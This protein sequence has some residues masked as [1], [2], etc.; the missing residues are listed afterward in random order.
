MS[1]LVVYAL[2]TYA[3]ARGLEML[4][5]AQAYVFAGLCALALFASVVA[6]EFAHALVARRF[7][8]CTSAITLFVFG[9]V[10][11]LEREPPTPRA[12]A[13]IALAG[14]AFSALL[15]VAAFGLMVLV[16]RV[17]PG[18]SGVALGL[19]SA[20]LA[21]AN[22]VLAVFNLVPAYPMDGGRVL[23]AL[24]WHLRR[25]RLWATA[26]AAR[27]AM[28]FA[29]ALIGVGGVCA[30]VM[31]SP[32]YGWYVVLGVFLFRQG[33]LEERAARAPASGVKPGVP[34]AA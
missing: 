26:I 16:E 17:V 4:P 25:D 18:R 29:F 34:A 2:V 20:Y 6:H 14:P 10:A 12:E 28:G 22:G 15:A 11:T 19:L 24:L 1:W 8:V 30:L 32:I 5:S 27:I 21:L 3:L 31:R 13:G 33:W 23:R 7:G 9:G